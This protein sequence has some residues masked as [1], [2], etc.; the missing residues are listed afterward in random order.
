M[1]HRAAQSG[2]AVSA[3]AVLAPPAPRDLRA[4]RDP[5]TSSGADDILAA[6]AA[7]AGLC[8]RRERSRR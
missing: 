6:G 7:A 3:G 1:P 8:L 4:G 5:V 2:S